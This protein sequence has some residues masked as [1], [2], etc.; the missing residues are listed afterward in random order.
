MWCKKKRQK[1]KIKFNQYSIT[2]NPQI[3]DSHHHQSNNEIAIQKLERRI[4]LNIPT[5][6]T[7]SSQLKSEHITAV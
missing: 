5:T 7:A 4:I 1:R 6:L 3:L 2:L